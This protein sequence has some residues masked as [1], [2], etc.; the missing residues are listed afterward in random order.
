MLATTVMWFHPDP[1]EA[2][3]LAVRFCAVGQLIGLVELF[4]V[5]GQLVPGG[6][7]DWTMI[8]IL[9]PHT[10]TRLGSLARQLF[11]RLSVRAILTL[12]VIDTLVVG[13]L[14][15][16]PSS[17]ALIAAAVIM[18]IALIKRNHLTIDGSDQMMFVVLLTCL[19]GRLGGGP[20]TARAAVSSSPPSSLF[21]TSSPVSSRPRQ[22]TGSPAGRS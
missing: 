13:A 21:R 10:R 22:S 8:G 7:L 2:L 1:G 18:Q 11:R 9:S 19:L 14:L 4:L 3:N 12:A 20:F 17:V 5:R 16:W 15:V 6:F